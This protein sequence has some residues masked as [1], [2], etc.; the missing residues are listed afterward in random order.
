VCR[1][2]TAGFNFFV[3]GVLAQN[4]R[5]VANVTYLLQT[6]FAVKRLYT[7]T[8]EEPKEIKMDST[9]VLMGVMSKHYYT[10]QG[11]RIVVV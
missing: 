1:P 7:E 10:G 9:T 2:E 8:G 11:I 4:F 5:I 3:G 6:L